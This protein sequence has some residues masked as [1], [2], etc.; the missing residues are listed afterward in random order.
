MTINRMLNF[1]E[2]KAVDV[3]DF[4]GAEVIINLNKPL[5]NHLES[6]CD[7]L[8]DG[9]TLDNIFDRCEV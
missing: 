1:S 4:E 9:S 6:T 3:S 2:V 7:L 5:P 8:V